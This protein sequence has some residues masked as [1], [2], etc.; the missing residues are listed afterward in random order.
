MKSTFTSMQAIGKIIYLTILF[1]YP[2][3]VF[4][5]EKLLGEITEI[6]DLSYIIGKADTSG[7][8]KLNLVLPKGKKDV[9]LLIW[10]GGGA[11]SYVDR[12]QEMELCRTH[13]RRSHGIQMAL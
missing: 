8:Q 10:I 5:Q 1:F 7:K 3:L 4:S 6:R 12:N 13:Q 2:A 9:P 11:W